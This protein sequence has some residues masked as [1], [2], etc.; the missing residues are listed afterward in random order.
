ML[1]TVE[2]G[3]WNSSSAFAPPALRVGGPQSG[4]LLAAVTH[5]YTKAGIFSDLTQKVLCL[6]VQSILSVYMRPRLCHGYTH[7]GQVPEPSC[8]LPLSNPWN[9]GVSAALVQHTYSRIQ[10][11]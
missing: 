10:R 3:E 7:T 4:R 9:L 2:G 6:S 5:K 1:L 8:L 11:G